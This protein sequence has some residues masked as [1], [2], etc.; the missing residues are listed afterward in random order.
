MVND[1]ERH[2]QLVALWDELVHFDQF[3][4]SGQLV[5]LGVFIWTLGGAIILLVKLLGALGMNYR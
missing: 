3:I 2:T 4:C 5:K 1:S